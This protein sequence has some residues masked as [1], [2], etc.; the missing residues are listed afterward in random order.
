MMVNTDTESMKEKV[1][2]SLDKKTIEWLD[3]QVNAGSK[4][5]SR[6]HVIEVAINEKM[7]KE[8]KA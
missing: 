6:S 7:D 5:R 4:Y 2:V 8:A 1:S 3:A